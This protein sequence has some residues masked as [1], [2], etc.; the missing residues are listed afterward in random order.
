METVVEVEGG[1]RIGAVEEFLL[2]VHALEAVL[3]GEVADGV[4]QAVGRA[5][6][7]FVAV[8]GD[9]VGGED[10][11][12]VLVAAR[13]DDALQGAGDLRGAA[14][15]QDVV[16][17]VE[18]QHVGALALGDDGGAAPGTGGGGRAV[19]AVVGDGL[20]N[21][22]REDGGVGGLHFAGG[23][24]VAERDDDVQ[25]VVAGVVV[26]EA[27]AAA[28]AAAAGGDEAAREGR[29]QQKGRKTFEQ[30][31]SGSGHGKIL[32]RLCG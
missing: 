29:A 31:G 8:D 10:G 5:G 19:G 13:V 6:E 27:A 16:D 22:P 4:V 2:E 1:V 11:H 14:A 21:Q 15:E 17:A 7:D 23:Q 12:D 28:T 26:G 32:L 24:G 25:V 30:V 20:A 3:A 9:G 18:D